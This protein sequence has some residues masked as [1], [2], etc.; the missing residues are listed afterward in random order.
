MKSIYDMMGRHTYPILRE[1]APLEHVERFFQVSARGRGRQK[2]KE[3]ASAL[4]AHCSHGRCNFPPASGWL[5]ELKP[6]LCPPSAEPH[7]RADRLMDSESADTPRPELLPPPAAPSPPGASL[8]GEGVEVTALC[9]WGLGG[10]R[11]HL[12]L[13]RT[14]SHS[15]FPAVC[16]GDEGG[17]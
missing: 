1:D 4:R 17:P 7:L 6:S 10:P 13:L 3:G 8:R 5:N 11:L 16:Q 12:P 9:P 15:T 14:L 2:R